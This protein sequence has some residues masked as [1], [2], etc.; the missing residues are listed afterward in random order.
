M[1]A[2]QHKRTTAFTLV[3]VLTSIA[4]VSVLIA[5]LVPILGRA[6]G[7]ARETACLANLRGIGLTFESYLQAHRS[8]YPFAAPDSQ[9][10]VSPDPDQPTAS[11][12]PGYWDLSSYWPSLMHSIAPWREHFATWVCKGSPRVTGQPW[13]FRD[14][15]LQGLPSYSYCAG[16][17]A[18][19]ETWS[20][21]SGPDL[22]LI[23]PVR[24]QDVLF[25]SQKVLMFDSEQAHLPGDSNDR[26]RTPM[27]FVDGHAA[28][29]AK[30]RAT[31]P[32]TNPFRHSAVTLHDTPQGARGR[33]Y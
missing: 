3:E 20:G 9:F 22:A 29:R 15:G 7:S 16:F 8:T 19:P 17:L 6:K 28:S 13:L 21:S 24:T 4:I 14:V 18:R 10:I 12:S 31:A 2:T 25:P 27:L 30:S 1:N 32:V 23:A 26:D 5:I 33:D 11:V